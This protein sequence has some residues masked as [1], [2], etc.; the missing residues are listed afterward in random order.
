[1]YT[2]AWPNKK[3]HQIPH[4]FQI[5]IESNEATNYNTTLNPSTHPHM[6]YGAKIE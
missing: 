6:Y 5:S 3:N 4:E 2:H 1:M